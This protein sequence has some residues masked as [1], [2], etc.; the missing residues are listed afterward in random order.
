MNPASGPQRASTD[1][2]T[3]PASS[4]STSNSLEASV[5]K[6]FRERLST[7][8]NRVSER[9]NIK[10]RLQNR[11]VGFIGRLIERINNLRLLGLFSTTKSVANEMLKL[12]KKEEAMLLAS[13]EKLQNN[14]FSEQQVNTAHQQ[15]QSYLKGD[16]TKQQAYS[17]LAATFTPLDIKKISDSL[18]GEA[19]LFKSEVDE[20]KY[21]DWVVDNARPPVQQRNRE[22]YAT[23]HKERPFADAEVARTSFAST[24]DYTKMNLESFISQFQG[25]I[26]SW[27]DVPS[28]QFANLRDPNFQDFALR[29]CKDPEFRK[30]LQNNPTLRHHLLRARTI[31]IATRDDVGWDGEL[32]TKQTDKLQKAEQIRANRQSLTQY[33]WGGAL[34]SEG[35]PGGPGVTGNATNTHSTNFTFTNESSEVAATRMVTN[36]DSTQD[37]PKVCCPNFANAHEVGGFSEMGH[38]K[39]QEESMTLLGDHLP[40]LWQLGNPDPA[41]G[42]RMHYTEGNHLPPGGGITHRATFFLGQKPVTVISNTVAFADFRR[43]RSGNPIGKYSEAGDYKVPNRN[44][45]VPKELTEDQQKYM[46]R[47]K[48]DI[49][50]YLRNAKAQGVEYVVAGATG[51]GAFL[52]LI[53]I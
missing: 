41:H 50:G 23:A 47:V 8:F 7:D 51:C 40:T 38:P 19:A 6:L 37:P 36:F 11:K 2:T 21:E 3:S 15:I 30:L 46:D 16:I 22:Q 10:A 4:N 39:A 27:N 44:E 42:N 49:R 52:S 5:G 35:V 29:A 18:E 20:A 31:A 34:N 26:R 28:G 14:G 45:S 17:K 1:T 24:T 12:T 25:T 32:L 13:S 9:S 43:D 33:D 48:L 53:H